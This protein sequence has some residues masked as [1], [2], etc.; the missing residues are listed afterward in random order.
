VNSTSHPSSEDS[1]LSR[2]EVETLC[3][4]K[5]V[6][7]EGCP[8]DQLP[9]RL[10]LSPMLVDA[11]STATRPLIDTGLLAIDSGRIVLT[12]RGADLLASAFARS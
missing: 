7:P 5:A 4:L 2:A 3:L 8:P 10:G 12:S 11:L 1:R 9:A 6:G